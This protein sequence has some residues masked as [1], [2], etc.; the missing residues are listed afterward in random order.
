MISL[1][2]KEIYALLDRVKTY[3]RV[4]LYHPTFI[5]LMAQTPTVTDITYTAD[6]KSTEEEERAYIYEPELDQILDFFET[7]VRF[8]LF[9]RS[10]LEVELARTSARL[11]A[12]IEAEQRATNLMT[13]KKQA[14]TKEQKSLTNARL[15]ETIVGARRWSKI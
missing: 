6:Q 13:E 12:M 5:S 15:I 8:L 7:H 2:Q 4:F 14:L 1:R 11:V 3:E 9:R 10:L